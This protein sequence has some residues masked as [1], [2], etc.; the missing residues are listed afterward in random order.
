MIELSEQDK[1]GARIAV[2]GVGGGGGNAVGT[3][4]RAGLNGV[5][6]VGR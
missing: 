6:F 5:D 1:Q 2:M 4:I 3:M